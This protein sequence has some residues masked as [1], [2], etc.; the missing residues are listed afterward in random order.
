MIAVNHAFVQ[1]VEELEQRVLS[2]K[3]FMAYQEAYYEHWLKQVRTI[4]A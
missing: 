1:F 2:Y 3:D 4:F